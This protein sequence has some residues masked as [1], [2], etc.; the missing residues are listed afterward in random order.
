MRIILSITVVLLSNFAFAG[1]VK[2][3][4]SSAELTAERREAS[5]SV[6]NSGATA[7]DI[8]FKLVPWFPEG[9]HTPLDESALLKR[10]ALLIY[11]PVARV[12]AGGRQ[13][14]RV[15]LRD[16]SITEL[17]LFRLQ[18][19]W[20][21]ASNQDAEAGKVNFGLGYSLPLMV[22]APKAEHELVYRA[23]NLDGQLSLEVTNKGQ[24]PVYI[25][26]YKWSDN[27]EGELF[28]YVW[29]NQS[30]YYKLAQAGPPPITVQLR[31]WGWSP[32]L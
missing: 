11:P 22:T 19:G 7:L 32:S 10:K 18:V 20:Q 25:K 28:G 9:V 24:L 2:V 3:F 29:P 26:R 12:E 17:A 14:F 27:S 5:F 31:T 4:P 30:H 8:K 15:I 16:R 6:T 23:V 13:V 21:A 1:G